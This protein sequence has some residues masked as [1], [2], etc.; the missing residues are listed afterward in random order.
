[1][2]PIHVDDKK[3]KMLKLEYERRLKKQVEDWMSQIEPPTDVTE[4]ETK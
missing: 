1:M 3:T 2:T 4:E